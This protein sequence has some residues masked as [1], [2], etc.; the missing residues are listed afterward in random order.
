MTEIYDKLNADRAIRVWAVETILSK[1]LVLPPTE[2]IARDLVS[3]AASLEHYMLHG[4]VKPDDTPGV[5]EFA[6]VDPA[7]PEPQWP[8]FPDVGP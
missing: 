4:T 2:T 5:P 7:G 1:C 6:E 3:A 8:G